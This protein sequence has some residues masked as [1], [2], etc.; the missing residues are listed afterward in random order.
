M[1]R[2]SKAALAAT[3]V[4]I[5]AGVFAVGPL[6]RARARRAVL[7]A[8]QRRVEGTCSVGR[9]SLARDGVLVED[10]RVEGA[11]GHHRAR[12]Q[13]VA[14]SF[15]W[16]SVLIGAEQPVDLR[17]SGVRVIVRGSLD[18]VARLPLR[19]E[20]SATRG[21]RRFSL[22]VVRASGVS[23]EAVVTGERAVEA[24]MLEGELALEPAVSRARWQELTVRHADVTA[25]TGRCEATRGAGAESVECVGFAVDADARAAQ[26]LPSLVDAALAAVRN[27][28]G[29][30][31]PSATAE[32][33][34]EPAVQR[35]LSAT[36]GAVRLRQ[37]RETVADLRPATVRAS[38]RGSTLESVSAQLGDDLGGAPSLA[39]TWTRD[40]ERWRAELDAAAIPLSRVA[41]WVPSVPWHDTGNGVAR[42]RVRVRPDDAR[43]F[44]IDGELSLE[45]FGLEHRGL[46][47]EP[48]DGLSASLR[49]AVR[50]ELGARRRVSTQRIEVAIN[51]VRFLAGGSVERGEGYTA[52]DASVNVPP[53]DCDLPRRNLPRA[54]LGPLAG[55]TFS[56]TI[57]MEARLV[58][59]TRALSATTLTSNVADACRVVRASGEVDV[60][61]FTAPFVQRVTQPDGLRAFITGPSAPAW[62]PYEQV[63]PFV[64]AAVVQRED[65][66]FFRHRGF[67]PDE[68]RGALVR[69]V[70]LG[71]FAYGASTL[72]MQ[73][74]K[75]VF[76]AREKT[77]VRKLQEVAL[78]WWL[79]RTLDKRSILELYLNVVEFGPEIYGIGPAA[80]F[81]FGKEPSQ[82]TV[83][84]SAYLATL[85]P[86]PVPRF[87][88][89]ERGIIGN[90]TLA[91]LRAI[92][93]G[94]AANPIVGPDAAREAQ[95][96]GITFRPRNTP[97]PEPQTL[98]VPPETT[99][100][101]AAERVRALA[102][103][104]A[105]S[106]APAEPPATPEEP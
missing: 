22:G 78:T 37:G 67:S 52:I 90:D 76:L 49:G 55:F 88:I 45:D 61:R 58:L 15:R 14:A 21:R 102:V 26:T 92:A 94:M 23:V 41:R 103:R 91:R 28:R 101:E 75:N 30:G 9:I 39:V 81:F 80:R 16:T 27:A 63:S 64:V 73:L 32:P 44:D 13:R 97:P 66:G 53:T 36:D 42:A 38:L 35:T 4:L 54:V 50:V 87:S 69:N 8:C 104:I 95:S 74:V 82:L 57:G 25:R 17:V 59:D 99:D 60:A 34:A 24:R 46:A 83:L 12:V 65:G 18:E 85:L 19:R 93:R 100:A 72:S 77:L 71:R 96:Q 31:E 84:E 10:V 40:G 48:V 5:V 68:I 2:G 105:P 89:F 70:S 11:G 29:D 6:A 20:V 51:G 1:S 98:M 56:G 3:L 106:T 33:S 47:R 7:T 79:E 86:A 43:V 62:T